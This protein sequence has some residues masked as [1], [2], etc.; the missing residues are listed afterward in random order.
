MVRPF[1]AVS[2]LQGIKMNIPWRPQLSPAL[3]TDL[4]Q[5]RVYSAWAIEADHPLDEAAA[6]AVL[7]RAVEIT[8]RIAGWPNALRAMLSPR[9]NRSGHDFFAELAEL[10]DYFSG[11]LFDG[12]DF[13]VGFRLVH[14]DLFRERSTPCALS[15]LRKSG[16]PGD[17]FKP[18]GPQS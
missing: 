17:T 11:E 14:T 10:L 18:P 3:E 1:P 8:R 16:R 15:M 2:F 5:V 13:V 6:S 4:Q 7:A 9:Q 12:F